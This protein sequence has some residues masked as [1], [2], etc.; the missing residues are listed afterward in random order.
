MVTLSNAHHPDE[1]Q[2]AMIVGSHV[3][4]GFSVPIRSG[5]PLLYTL[6]APM[7]VSS[8]FSQ[9]ITAGE[10]YRGFEPF[11]G[12]SADYY[13]AYLSH[14]GVYNNFLM[15][16]FVLTNSSLELDDLVNEARR[17]YQIRAALQGGWIKWGVLYGGT[18]VRDL[19]YLFKETFPDWREAIELHFSPLR[20]DPSLL[21]ECFMSMW[22]KHIL[23]LFSPKWN[24]LQD[25]IY[26][27]PSV[28]R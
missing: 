17:I 25:Q 24:S 22:N 19:I 14:R 7:T 2:I 28:I 27:H 6:I 13:T 8:M 12:W 11:V 18:D 23:P 26:Q 4:E 15:G 10:S 20:K 9:V 3:Y 21:K 16:T 1:H 5:S